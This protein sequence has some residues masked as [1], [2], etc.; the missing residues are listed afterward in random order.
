MV[1]ST[2]QARLIDNPDLLRERLRAAPAGPGVYVMRDLAGSVAYV[3]KADSLQNRLRSYFSGIPSLPE[4]T[5]QLVE[6]VFDFEV[7]ASAST[8]EAL[9]LENT[10]IKR[11]RPRFNIRLKDD[12]NYLYLKIPQPGTPD[13]HA[14]GTAREKLRPPRGEAGRRATYYPRPY[15]T[16][17]VRR[18]GARYF[19]P[20]TERTVAAHDGALAAHHLSVPHLQR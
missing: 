7:I 18:D 2:R 5:R 10:L 14:P 4:R 12:K 13:M 17:R 6:R 15:Y 1:T 20:Y 8:R 9:I 3:G 16:R 19:G 11:Y